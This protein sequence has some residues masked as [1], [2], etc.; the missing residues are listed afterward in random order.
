MSL[1]E[2]FAETYFDPTFELIDQLLPPRGTLENYLFAK[3]YFIN[4]KTYKQ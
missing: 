4:K 3:Q 2:W 1:P